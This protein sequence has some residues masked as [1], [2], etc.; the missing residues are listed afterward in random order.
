MGQKLATTYYCPKCFEEL[1]EV[2]APM[3]ANLICTD[4][5]VIT[6][7]HNAFTKQQVKFAEKR[8]LEAQRN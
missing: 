2:D 6:C 4:C 1:L 8:N 7:Y 5:L 3:H